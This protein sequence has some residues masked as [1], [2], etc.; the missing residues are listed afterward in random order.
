[1]NLEART[2]QDVIDLHERFC[3]GFEMRDPAGVMEIIAPDADV[4]IVTS[5]DALLRGI[6]ELRAFLDNY[7]QGPTTYSWVW[8]RRDVSTAGS[9]AWLLA[10]GSETAATRDIKTDHPYRMTIVCQKRSGRWH[11]VHAHGSSPHT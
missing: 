7:V 2:T 9:V 3:R 11:L 6:E 4:I 8:T 10:E 1:M 5:E